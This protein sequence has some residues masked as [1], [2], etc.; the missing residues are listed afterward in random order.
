MFSF[1]IAPYLE[2]L[3]GTQY[4]AN[5]LRKKSIFLRHPDKMTAIFRPVPTSGLREAK[6]PNRS[7]IRTK[8]PKIIRT[9]KPKICQILGQPLPALSWVLQ[10]LSLVNVTDENN[11][12][13]KH[14]LAIISHLFNRVDALH[15][16][17]SGHEVNINLANVNGRAV[18]KVKRLSGISRLLV[19]IMSAA[20]DS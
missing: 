9:L 17:W 7:T 5:F 14:K 20:A 1:N 16:L 11:S 8:H 4:I 12:L 6:L 13:S 19:S 15:I 18:T 3:H 2:A 10:H